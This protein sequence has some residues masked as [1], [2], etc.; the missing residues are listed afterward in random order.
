MAIVA[1]ILGGRVLAPVAQLL[2]QWRQIGGARV[3]RRRLAELLELVPAEAPGLELPPPGQHLVADGVSARVP[4]SDQPVLKDVKLACRAGEMVAVIGPSGCGKSTLARVLV[5]LWPSQGG[6]VRLDGADVYQWH[7]SQLGPSVG[8]LPQAVE[9]F[10]G[11]VAENI[12]RFD[13]VDEPKLRQAIED[14]GIGPLIDSLPQGLDTRIGDGGVQ[15]SGGERQRVGLARAAYGDVASGRAG[16]A[17]R[18]PGRGW[19]SGAGAFD[20]DPEG[21][22][23][24][25]RRHHPPGAGAGSWPN[26]CF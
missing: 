19:R 14:A 1:S 20:R 13:R 26:T 11:T 15:L 4:G 24:H 21:A 7:K 12:A 3:A 23:R 22:R 25:R 16:R 2:G 17:Q 5:G 6:K 10:D 9:L 18:E 8:Y